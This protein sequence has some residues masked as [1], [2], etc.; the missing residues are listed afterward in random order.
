M[1]DKTYVIAGNYREFRYYSKMKNEIYVGDKMGLFG[2]H[3]PN[4]KLVGTFYRR[5]DWLE[6]KEQ[7]QLIEANIIY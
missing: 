7:L 3:G 4:V 5:K 6:L 1:F 2:L